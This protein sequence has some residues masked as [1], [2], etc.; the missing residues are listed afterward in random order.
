M[1]NK[2]EDKFP[3]FKNKE[4]IKITDM[5]IAWTYNPDIVIP[6][7]NTYHEEI[8]EKHCLSKSFVKKVIER[9]KPKIV[10]EKPNPQS[11]YYLRRTLSYWLAL[12]D[13]L[14]ELGIEK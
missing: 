8:I 12:D 13:I 3:E 7:G 11:I 2:F 1:N 10:F 5:G 9:N 6:K 4:A 14:N